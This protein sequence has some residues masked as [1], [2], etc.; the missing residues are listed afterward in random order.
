[1]YNL[2]EKPLKS[3]AVFLLNSRAFGAHQSADCIS[4]ELY[5][6]SWHKTGFFPQACAGIQAGRDHRRPPVQ[7][8]LKWPCLPKLSRAFSSWCRRSP[9]LEIIQPRWAL[10]QYVGC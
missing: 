6:E 3:K 10:V 4:H 9:G 8:L 7:S 2:K 5:F 1:M